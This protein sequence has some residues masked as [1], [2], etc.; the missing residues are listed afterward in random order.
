MLD[1]CLNDLRRA[2]VATFLFSVL[3][4]L[5]FWAFVPAQYYEL[6]TTDFT[7]RDLPMAQQIVDGAPFLDPTNIVAVGFPLVLVGMIVLAH[8]FGVP[9]ALVLQ[10]LALIE[11]GITSVLILLLARL[12][13][14]PLLAFVAALLWTTYPFALWLTKQTST[15]LSF[16]VFF[17][18]A[19]Y[20]WWRGLVLVRSQLAL[21]GLAGLLIGLAM[22]IRPFAA[23]F[24]LVMLLGIICKR[25]LVK[26]RLGAVALLCVG[27]MSV[28]LPWEFLVRSET[29]RW[30]LL[31]DNG[32]KSIRDGLSFAVESKSYRAALDVPED[33]K[34]LMLDARSQQATLDSSVKIGAFLWDN[35]REQPGTVM[36]FLALKAVRAWYATDSQR[37]EILSAGVQLVYLLLGTLGIVMTWRHRP[38][39]RFL[40]LMGL[41]TVLYFWLITLSALPILRYMIPAMGLVIVFI[42]GA[43]YLPRLLR[44]AVAQPQMENHP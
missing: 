4:T 20:F 35:F 37:F 1:W 38:H 21:F 15:E 42:P 11:M 34:A 26:N 18:A 40:V 24:P 30:V 27:C 23:G 7:E 10:G 3:V 5:V 33:I 41:A 28:V 29:G 9:L 2:V 17:F 31:N 8:T 22:L 32:V 13:W 39:A 6:G 12:I 14:T 25:T 43:V 44:R 16:M 36:K 19:V